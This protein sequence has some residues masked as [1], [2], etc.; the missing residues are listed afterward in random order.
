MVLNIGLLKSNIFIKW[1]ITKMRMLKW[2]CENT[3]KERIQTGKIHLKIGVALINEK[4]IESHL[5]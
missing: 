3:H 2:I 5:K 1:G 4:M